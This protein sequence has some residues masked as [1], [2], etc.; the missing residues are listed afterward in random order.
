MD[1]TQI[2]GREAVLQEG[3]VPSIF[4]SIAGLELD[5]EIILPF[6]PTQ[7]GLDCFVIQQNSS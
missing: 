1:T 4:G 5:A 3:V 2:A 7:P 6:E